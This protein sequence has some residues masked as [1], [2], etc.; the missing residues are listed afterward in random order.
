MLIKGF[1][2]SRLLAGLVGFLALVVLAV[3]VFAQAAQLQPIKVRLSFLTYGF[4][5]GI[6]YALEKGW[7]K[8]GGLD[9]SIEDGTGSTNTVSVVGAG[10]YDIGEAALSVMAQGRNKGLPIKAIAGF[11]PTSDAGVLV[12]VDSNIKTLKDLAGKKVIYS[13]SS[14]EAPFL[15]IFFHNG[16]ITRDQMELINIDGMAKV[17]AYVANRADALITVVPAIQVAVQ[18]DRPSRGILFGDY[19]LIIPSM[20]YFATEQTIKEKPQALRVFVAAMSRAFHEIKDEDKIDEAIADVIKN[21]P[22]QKF[23]A[24]SLKAQLQ[25]I[26]PFMASPNTAGKPYGWE[27]SKDWA[28]A[29]KT[30][31]DAGQLDNK[32]TPDEFFTNE[33]VPTSYK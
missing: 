31:R 17:S 7:F 20:G 22:Q 30:M 25:A 11:E 4:H 15:D 8:D 18:K 27:A 14:L 28:V 9:V 2:R 24:D 12:P 6:F 10:N 21:R 33:F 1:Y 32:A 3:P 29:V 26:Y 16:G 5:A 13:A 19:G 23:G